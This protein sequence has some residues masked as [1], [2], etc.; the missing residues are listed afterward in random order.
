LVAQN[1]II[2]AGS[3]T[4]NTIAAASMLVKGN[5]GVSGAVGNTGELFEQS[6]YIDGA[7]NMRLVDWLQQDSTTIG[8][9]GGSMHFGLIVDGAQG[10]VGKPQSQMIFDPSGFGTGSIGLSGYYGGGL[11]VN[12]AGNTT[13]TSGGSLIF[14][15]GTGANGTMISADVT[16]NL[17]LT[18]AV[19]NGGGLTVP[20]SSTIGVNTPTATVFSVSPAV[21]AS[22][23]TWGWNCS[24]GGG[25]ACVQVSGDAGSTQGFAIYQDS[26]ANLLSSASRIFG[27]DHSGT[28]TILGE[29]YAGSNIYTGGN[30]ALILRTPSGSRGGT[31]GSDSAGDVVLGSAASG[32]KIVASRPVVLAS[33]AF[34]SLPATGN[35][36]AE[37]FC[38]DCLKPS[39]AAGAG[40]GMIVFDDGHSH[41]VSTAGTIAAN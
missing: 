34:R 19:A 14:Q 33:A 12:G 6:G 11:V 41:W 16:G 5:A 37:L 38:T 39:E 2:I 18:S 20:R 24:N 27:V 31:V 29:F 32:G 21:N 3:A 1:G 26:S 23:A 9:A 4:I 7:N 36:G 17:R 40:T 30:A 15:N 8:A 28:E 35:P 10:S 22:S 25:E 13:L